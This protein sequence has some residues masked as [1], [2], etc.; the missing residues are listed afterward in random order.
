MT[1]ASRRLQRFALLGRG[2]A[3]S[4]RLKYGVSGKNRRMT[5]TE[6]MPPAMPAAIISSETGNCR[7]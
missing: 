4:M 7:S 2:G 6:T 1:S 3:S 5:S